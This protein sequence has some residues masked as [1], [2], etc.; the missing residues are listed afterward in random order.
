MGN[1]TYCSFSFVAT[2]FDFQF[3][4]S[5]YFQAHLALSIGQKKLRHF[6]R[7]K[8]RRFLTFLRDGASCPL[9]SVDFYEMGVL[10]AASGHL[11]LAQKSFYE[12]A[13][14]NNKCEMKLH[15]SLYGGILLGLLL[16]VLV[17]K[18]RL[19][20]LLDEVPLP[21]VLT[22][23]G[24]S[25]FFFTDGSS[26][27]RWQPFW[28]GSIILTPYTSFGNTVELWHQTDNNIYWRALFYAAIHFAC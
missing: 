7:E 25:L 24:T 21:L 16:G 23:W 11:L 10:F 22:S 9:R 12:M 27:A 28:L 18:W 3:G 6:W 13:R 14:K 4:P 26:L 17:R 19:T 1:S 8:I 20:F 2:I 5:C 15:S